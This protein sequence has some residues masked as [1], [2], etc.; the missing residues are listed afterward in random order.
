MGNFSFDW[1]FYHFKEIAHEQASSAQVKKNVKRPRDL[2]GKLDIKV[3]EERAKQVQFVYNTMFKSADI[4][5]TCTA[6]VSD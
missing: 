1:L 6:R 2:G 5:D 3:I 4:R